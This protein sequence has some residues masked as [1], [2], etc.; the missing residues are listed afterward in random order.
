MLPLEEN[1]MNA[2]YNCPD[3]LRIADG[4]AKSSAAHRNTFHFGS[5]LLVSAPNCSPPRTWTIP[6][7]SNKCHRTFSPVRWTRSTELRI[8]RNRSNFPGWA[9][10]ISGRAPASTPFR[11][12]LTSARRSEWSSCASTWSGFFFSHC[13]KLWNSSARPVRSHLIRESAS[14]WS[15]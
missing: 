11:V 9:T 7:S 13:T 8:S 4:I 10:R 3:R 15:F 5:K 12:L 14:E 2:T 1:K 6:A